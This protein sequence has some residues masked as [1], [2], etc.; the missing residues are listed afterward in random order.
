MKK[1]K[2]K[3]YRIEEEWDIDNEKE[4]YT[5]TVKTLSEVK[6]YIEGWIEGWKESCEENGYEI[7]EIDTD[8][9]TFAKIIINREYAID[10]IKLIVKRV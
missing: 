8:F 6:K 9:K 2:I 3:E 5:N 1:R 4:H 7:E 10:E